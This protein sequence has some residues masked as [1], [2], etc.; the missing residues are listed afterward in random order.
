MVKET[1]VLRTKPEAKKRR[2]REGDDR[3]RRTTE[4]IAEL[5]KVFKE[6]NISLIVSELPHGSQN[7]RAAVMIGIVTGI[8][9]TFS[10]LLSIPIEWYS[11]ND[12]KKALFGRISASKAE[13]IRSINELYE[14]SWTGTKYADEAIAD[15]LAIYYVAECNS[16]TIKFMNR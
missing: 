4:I 6:Y 8:L 5:R 10:Y 11:E 12:A 14:V 1:G 3:V 2:I 9:Q 13:V 15:A 16:P 7:A